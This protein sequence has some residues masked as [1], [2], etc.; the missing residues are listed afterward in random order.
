MY[1]LD[2]HFFSDVQE[3]AEHLEWEFLIE[4]PEDY[5]ITLN[6]CDLE[7]IG[8]LNGEVIAERAFDEDRFSEEPYDQQK[9]IIKILDD[10]INWDEINDLLPKLWYPNS[11]KI[12]FTKQELID[13]I[14]AYNE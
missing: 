14:K 9:E 13:S 8:F 12:V 4:Q 10:R 3:I 7:T 11:T 6:E 5:T 1:N 2:E